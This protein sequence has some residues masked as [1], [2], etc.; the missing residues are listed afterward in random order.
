MAQPI[1]TKRPDVL[2]QASFEHIDALDDLRHD[3]HWTLTIYTAGLAVECVLQ[4][5]ALRAGASDDAKHDLRKWLAKCPTNLQTIIAKDVPNEWSFLTIVW[6]NAIRYLSHDGLLGHLRKLE[7]N[8]GIK[9][10]KDGTVAILKVNAGRVVTAARAVHGKGASTWR[11][12]CS[13]K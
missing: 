7:L 10:G 8:K 11:Q 6:F 13:K 4:A 5:I 12:V 2:Y 3:R 9:Q 1:I